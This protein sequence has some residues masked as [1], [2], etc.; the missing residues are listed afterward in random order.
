M[1]KKVVRRVGIGAVAAFVLWCLAGL[2]LVLAADVRFESPPV[3][4]PNEQAATDTVEGQLKDVEALGFRMRDGA[5][6]RARRFA[7]AGSKTT[8]VLLHGVMSMARRLDPMARML[9]TSTGAEVITLDLRGH[10]GS[11]GNPGDIAYIGQ[12]E[13][14]VADVI[15]TVRRDR[16]GRTIV[17]AGHSMGGGIVLRYADRRTLPPVDRYLLFAPLMGP[18]SPTARNEPRD[19]NGAGPASGLK[20]HMPRT[21]GLVMLN[22]VGFR[23]LNGRRTLFFNVPPELA[24]RS[25]SFRAM[26]GMTPADHRSALQ[27]D[28]TPLFAMVGSADGAFHVDRFPEVIGQHQNGHVKIIEGVDHPGLVMSAAAANAAGDWL[29]GLR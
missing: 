16:P 1:I 4:P 23:G 9:R 20:V 3:L 13:D 12:Y 19:G 29:E 25:Y 6:L 7:A 14:D 18:D 27:A 15:A 24:L 26:A 2:G 8:I 28:A 5:A 22:L 11:D 17:L 10:G 21:I